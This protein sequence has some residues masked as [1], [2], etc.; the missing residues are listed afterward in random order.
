MREGESERTRYHESSAQSYD[1][2]SEGLQEKLFTGRNARPSKVVKLSPACR[3]I[4]M[5]SNVDKL[6]VGGRGEANSTGGVSNVTH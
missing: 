1:R 5:W 3:K 4:Q 6:N 2:L